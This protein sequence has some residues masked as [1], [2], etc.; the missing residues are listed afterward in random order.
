MSSRIW[1]RSSEGRLG[2]SVNEV[3]C[4]GS[5]SDVFVRDMLMRDLLAG[6]RDELEI[7]LITSF[8]TTLF[9]V[10]CH[11]LESGLRQE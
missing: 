7:I 5:F 6:E 2:K 8:V 3:R 4:E 9:G 10:V 1:R 11:V